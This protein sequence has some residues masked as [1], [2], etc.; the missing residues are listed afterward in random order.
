MVGR[1]L[2]AAAALVL[3]A[4]VPAAADDAAVDAETER[5]AELAVDHLFA[6]TERVLR[7]ADPIRIAGAPYCGKDVG[8]VL[9]VFTLND[10]T[11]SQ[12]GA[13]SPT[14][15]KSL[16]RAVEK[17]FPLDE[18]ERIAVVAPGLPAAKAGLQPGDVVTK[19]GGREVSKRD[20]IHT[21]KLDDPNAPLELT[22]EREGK[23]LV[24]PVEVRLGCAYPAQAWY[25]NDINAFAG[26]MG[27]L[28]GSYVFGG[29][30]AFASSD[31]ELAIVLGHELSHLILYSGGTKRSEAD[32]DY[33]GLYLAARAGFDVTGAPAFWDRM[34]R[35]NPYSNI[36][37]GFYA[38]PSSPARAV[39]LQATLD[40]IAARK[41]KGGA[42][43]PDDVGERAEPPEAQ[44][45]DDS[46]AM[47]QIR[48]GALAEL[49]QKRERLLRVGYR[50]RTGGAALCGDKTAPALGALLA[51]RR[52]VLF[53][54]QKEAEEIFGVV[55]EVKVLA[56]VP[57][58]PAARA[59][60]QVGDLVLAVNGSDVGKTQDV[61]AELRSART[62]PPKLGLSRGGQ[63]SDVE[64]P[65]VAAC[66]QEFRLIMRGSFDPTA[67][68][69]GDDILVPEGLLRFAR[70]DDELGIVLAHQIAHHQ[71]GTARLVSSADEPAADKLGL[72][73]AAKAG[74]DVSKAPA[75]LD[76][77]VAEDPWKLDTGKRNYGRA[78]EHIGAAERAL[79]VK[80]A[81]AALLKGDP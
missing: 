14:F 59:G 13:D 43:E 32:A 36:S 41:A 50:V 70:D 67:D 52:D 51:R 20:R 18:R 4:A 78:S 28:T 63:R 35:A 62:Q 55:D 1:F 56:L 69:N 54:K 48:A 81:S 37:W 12:F 26:H 39:A 19:I 25:G 66:P 27:K 10:K 49:E 65:L 58:S 47:K 30:L 16:T 11:F 60:V 24:V 2:F 46:E 17:R 22:V 6:G 3:A 57:D 31:D 76:R 38:H 33:L 23:E 74:F 73:I 64:L 9:G 72:A 44:S 53:G 8:A 40:E 42:L 61:Y 7:V 79:T 21:L 77:M 29:M 80:S 71:L 34:G 5:L 68:E 15:E 75:L 45:G